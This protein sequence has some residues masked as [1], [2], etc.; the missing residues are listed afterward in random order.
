M[1]ILEMHLF[2]RRFRYGDSGVVT[3]DWV[4]L[5][6]AVVGL[7]VGAFGIAGSATQNASTD[8]SDQISSRALN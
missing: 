7:A 3:V 5:T 8:T 6:A 4:V 2:F 1:G